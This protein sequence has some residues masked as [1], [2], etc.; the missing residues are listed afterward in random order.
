[1]IN[2]SRRRILAVLAASALPSVGRGEAFPS[3]PI[4]MIVPWP[5]GGAAD[6]TTR[7]IAPH[8]EEVLGQPIVVENR[9]GAQGQ[10]GALYVSRSPPDGYTILRSDNVSLVL[11]PTFSGEPMYDPI[12]DFAPISL[13]GRGFL[14]LLV[15]TTLGLNSIAELVALAK[16]KPG[17]LNY[18]AIPG[19]S[20]FLSSERFKQATGT[21]IKLV[22]YKGEGAALPDLVAGH[23][24]MMFVF[25]SAAL[26]FVRAGR[27]KALL[28]TGASRAPSLP[29]VP[30]GLEAGMP[31]V[32]HYGWGGF[33]APPGTPRPIIDKLSAAVV[34]ASK[35]P[36]VQKAVKDAGSEIMAGTPEQ[37]A[38]FLR[39][40]LDRWVP[41]IRSL[42]FKA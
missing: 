27:V 38:A 36:D 21:D 7:R 20:S 11:A 29:D 13:Q 1:M 42:N 31:E 19:S 30:T 37:F 40:E 28:V 10:L 9:G 35:A 24:Q 16:A 22:T 26:P 32:E 2:Q 6:V 3:K 23:V 4:R 15:P 33:M 39:A 17:Q 12:E 41:V 8:M 14:A 18:A 5:A 34:Q 25:M